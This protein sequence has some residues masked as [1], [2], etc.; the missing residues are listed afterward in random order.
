MTDPEK[1]DIDLV[2]LERTCFACPSQWD[3]WDVD[4]NYYY[5][6][7]RGGY[8]SVD[9]SRSVAAMW[10]TNERTSLLGWDTGDGLD[11]FMTDTEMLD[12]TGLRFSGIVKNGMDGEP[13]A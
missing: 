3:A 11:G 1:L 6:R 7:F 9:R 12:L 10:D 8:L 2:R 5:I 13:D 4:N